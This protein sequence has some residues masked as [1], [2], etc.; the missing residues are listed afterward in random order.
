M[1]NYVQLLSLW[2]HKS[3]DEEHMRDA[4]LHNTGS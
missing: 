2:A 4:S 1:I 3:H